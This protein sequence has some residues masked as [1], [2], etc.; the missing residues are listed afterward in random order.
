MKIC[1][2]SFAF[3][4]HEKFVWPGNYEEVHV[5]QNLDYRTDCCAV[6][7]NGTIVLFARI[8]LYTRYLQNNMKL[9]KKYLRILFL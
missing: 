9:I 6:F 5:N 8:F 4:V 3:K 7:I 1:D 2:L